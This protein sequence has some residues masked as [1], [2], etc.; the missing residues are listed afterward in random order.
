MSH[1][2]PK[3][4]ETLFYVDYNTKIRFELAISDFEKTKKVTFKRDLISCS[5]AIIAGYPIKGDVRPDGKGNWL[6]PSL[7]YSF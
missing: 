4:I 2:T 5:G 3:L 6:L 1:H 7:F